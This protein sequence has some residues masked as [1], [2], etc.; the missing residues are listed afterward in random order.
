[1]WYNGI[2]SPTKGAIHMAA[3]HINEQ[4]LQELIDSKKDSWEQ[5]LI[6]LLEA[7]EAVS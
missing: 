7:L 2:N 6:D 4:Q 5:N 3:I 1:M